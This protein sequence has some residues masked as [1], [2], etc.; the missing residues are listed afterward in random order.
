MPHKFC[1]LVVQDAYIDA[2]LL[3]GGRDAAFI[4]PVLTLAI[5]HMVALDAEITEADLDDMA[6]AAGQDL[7][8]R[9]DGDESSDDYSEA[10][11]TDAASVASST[12]TAGGATPGTMGAPG[13]FV[14][15]AEEESMPDG[16]NAEAPGDAEIDAD[17]DNM[18]HTAAEKLD[19]LFLKVSFFLQPLVSNPVRCRLSCT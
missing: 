18:E 8:D 3:L 1:D 12:F 4:E 5:E 19:C 15:D 6:A 7:D 9:D 2:L 11:T 14:M 17:T 16:S 13:L 10:G